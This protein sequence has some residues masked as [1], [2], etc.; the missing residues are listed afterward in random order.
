MQLSELIRLLCEALK[1]K[2]DELEQLKGDLATS[3]V[4]FDNDV[5][6]LS[7]LLREYTNF[8]INESLHA[9]LPEKGKK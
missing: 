1:A 5:K 4:Q 8:S 3:Q 6:E 2:K 7:N 9:L